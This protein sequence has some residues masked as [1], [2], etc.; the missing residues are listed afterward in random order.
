MRISSA[1][2]SFME[3][4]SEPGHGFDS[5]LVTMRQAL[6]RF[7]RKM[8]RMFTAIALAEAGNLDAVKELLEQEQG[9]EKR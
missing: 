7:F 1:S 5:P 2:A 4:S 3:H 6:K 9:A 8:D